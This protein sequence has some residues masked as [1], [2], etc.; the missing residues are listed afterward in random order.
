MPKYYITS[1][2]L[3]ITLGL[4]ATT[5]AQTGM[6]FLNIGPN[7]HSLSLSE[8]HTAVD[9]G[10][11]SIF[12]NPANL[13]LSDQ[14]SLGISYTL[15]IG[16]TQHTQVSSAIRRNNDVFAVGLL[17]SVIDD[18]SLRNVPGPSEGSFSVQYLALS[19]AYAR[20]ISFISAGVSFSYLYEQLFQQ[21]ASGFGF[22]AGLNARFL[23]E[24]L[25]TAV[26]LTNAGQMSKLDI[27]RSKLPTRI[28]AGIDVDAIQ[29]SAFGGNEIPLLITISTDF[30]Q[31]IEDE[32]FAGSENAIES[33]SF[34]TF[35]LQ[36]ELYD[37]IGIRGGYR[38]GDTVR[39]W[40][41]GASINVEP[42]TFHYAFVPFETGFGM[43]HSISLQY[44]FN[45]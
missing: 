28:R 9:L 32:S 22:S 8:A 19:A 45:L 21:N 42:I 24:R 6:D 5:N 43:V 3:L 39:R 30:V 7:A 31:P 4:S 34:F 10:S 14:S 29:L 37:M 27:E 25:R 15:W 23:D 33:G 20:N 35:G 41:A 16:D 17:S 12:T 40:S 2:L 36:A 11:N 44:F 38:T 13:M 1:A 18:I 26:A